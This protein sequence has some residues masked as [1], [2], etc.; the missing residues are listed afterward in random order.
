MYFVLH[1]I[2]WENCVKIG[3]LYHLAAIGTIGCKLIFSI[4]SFIVFLH[5]QKIW[6]RTIG[7][8]LNFSMKSFVVFYAISIKFS[9]WF[10]LE[11]SDL[12]PL[13]LAFS[14]QHWVW[15]CSKK[16]KVQLQQKLQNSEQW[17]CTF[18]IYLYILNSLSWLMHWLIHWAIRPNGLRYRAENL[19]Q[20]S[21]DTIINKTG[22]LD[23]PTGRG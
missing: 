6:S 8:K 19:T 13:N 12:F 11:K 7:C 18:S 1:F 20:H 17:K 14:R 21:W 15:F 23:I 3:R 2:P 9:D 22:F 16:Y 10:Y 4:K 5:S